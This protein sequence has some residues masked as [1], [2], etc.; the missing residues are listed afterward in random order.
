MKLSAFNMMGHDN[1]TQ[2]LDL[3]GVDKKLPR[4]KTCGLLFEKPIASKN[5]KIKKKLDISFTYDG[6][7]IASKNFVDS[8]Y[9]FGGEGL[10]FSKLQNSEGFYSV[11]ATEIVEYSIAKS[12][13]RF[14]N[15]SSCCERFMEIIGT[16]PIYTQ[17]WQKLN[18]Y[19]AVR[20]DLTF[21]SFNSKHPLI[22]ISENMG[23]KLKK[24]KFKGL[25]LEKLDNIID[26]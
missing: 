15:F 9:G 2:M 24:L 18:N 19:A 21:G 10:K 26:S 22:L 12:E 7:M 6:Y 5:F 14:I 1:E 20:T 13:V 17:D 11:Y 23:K 8:W 25:V 4:C 16:H 3:F